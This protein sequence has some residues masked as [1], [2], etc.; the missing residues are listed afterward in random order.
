MSRSNWFVTGCLCVFLGCGT[1]DGQRPTAPVEVSVTYQGSPLEG[2]TVTFVTTD[3][4]IAANGITDSKGVAQLS[5]YGTKDGAVVGN[6]LVMITKTEV[7]KSVKTKVVPADQADTV[8]YSPLTPLKSLIPGKY[9][10]P[11]TSG[12]QA[13]VKKGRNK[14]SFDLKN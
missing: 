11:G 12:L 13:E 14:F 6:N 2:A 1:P 3:E 4:P 8:G 7:D 10:A 5:T 9:S